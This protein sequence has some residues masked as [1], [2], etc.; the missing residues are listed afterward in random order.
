MYVLR[1]RNVYGIKK[2]SHK[3]RK[4]VLFIK[5]AEEKKKESSSKTD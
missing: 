1:K 3:N 5:L 4:N 2:N